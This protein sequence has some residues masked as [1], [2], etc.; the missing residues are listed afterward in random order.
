LRFSTS[1]GNTDTGDDIDHSLSASLIMNRLMTPTSGSRGRSFLSGV[2][3]CLSILVTS[4]TAVGAAEQDPNG[5]YGIRWGTR[6]AEVADLVQVESADPI[7][8]YELKNGPP[9]LDDAKVDVL[10]FIAIEGALAR[11]SIR[12]S[13]NNT[14]ARILAYFESHYG[15]FNRTPG[16]MMRGLNQQFTWRGSETEVNLTYESYRERGNVFVE[17]RTLAPRFSDVLPEHGY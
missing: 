4:P 6:L 5:F 11:V 13:G 14:H 10:R 15:S 17:S 8:S 12:Y 9:Q 2:G 3:L 16:S 7:Q 1:F